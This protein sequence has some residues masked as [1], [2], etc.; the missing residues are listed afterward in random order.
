MR[1]DIK[2]NDYTSVLDRPILYSRC[3]LSQRIM[4]VTL[5]ELR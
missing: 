1:Y 3:C 2:L 5:F 4:N